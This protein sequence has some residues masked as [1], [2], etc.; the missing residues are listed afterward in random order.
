MFMFTTT[1]SIVKGEVHGLGLTS[2]KAFL[3]NSACTP[4]INYSF[5]MFE[6]FRV[7]INLVSV[8]VLSVLLIINMLVL[9]S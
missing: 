1:A 7:S 6:N 9:T 5:I 8:F 3:R 2:T 4:V